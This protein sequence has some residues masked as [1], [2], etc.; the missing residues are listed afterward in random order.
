MMA[1]LATA[2][3]ANG[4]VA[5]WSHV[6]GT[7]VEIAPASGGAC[8][9]ST[10][11]GYS[12]FSSV[13]L[14]WYADSRARCQRR[15]FA[16]TVVPSDEHDPDWVGD[17]PALRDALAQIVRYAGTTATVLVLGETGTGK[18]LAARRIHYSGPRAEEPF[19]AVNCGA[20]PDALVE[21]ELFGHTR[22]AFTDAR[23]A[24]SGVVGLAERGTLFLDEVE[25]LSPR[26]QIVLLRF[27]QDRRYRPVGGGRERCADVRIIAASNQSL[28]EL[29]R[30]GAYRAD[31]VYRLA[32]MTVTL[33]PL[34]ARGDDVV[35]LA[36][37]FIARLARQYGRAAKSLAP[38]VITALRAH[39]WPGNVRE[40]ENLMHRAFVLCDSAVVTLRDLPLSP[41]PVPGVADAIAEPLLDDFQNAKRAAVTAFERRF[42][43][44]ALQQC[45][46][47]VS[48]AAR[49]V[50]KERRAFGKLMKKHG[51]AREPFEPCLSADG[52]ATP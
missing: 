51:I 39:P 6:H 31:L 43:I 8:S 27:L 33:P 13:S 44:H 36:E 34:R 21:S 12:S 1:R 15:G 14:G 11:T 47:N 22:G 10:P 46:G 4:S 3:W 50:G 2:S 40:L 26:A 7:R 52:A 32:V 18:E 9:L 24:Q 28:E 35:L 30:R 49:R 48:L 29:A 17:S 20:L 23:E 45:G 16:V 42:L 5:A 38:P 37:H 25:A 41:D 19:I